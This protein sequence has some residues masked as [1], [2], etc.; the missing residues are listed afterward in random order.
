MLA[1]QVTVLHGL[2]VPSERLACLA[3]AGGLPL[4][5]AED[6]RVGDGDPERIVVLVGSVD[7]ESLD[8]CWLRPFAAWI[9]LGI[10]SDA[11]VLNKIALAASGVLVASFTTVTANRLTLARDIVEAVGSRREIGSERRDDIEL[12]I[13]EAISNALV[14][15]NLQVESMKGLT[16]SALDRF[17]ED[18]SR[19][20]SDPDFA[21]RRL[22]VSC[23]LDAGG[24]TVEIADQGAGFIVVE[25]DRCGPCGRGLDLISGIAQS[26]QLLDGGRR[27]RMRFDL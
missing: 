5:P 7:P 18:I 19:R 12:A 9:E 21:N 4:W 26:C 14:H 27:I 23:E 6:D 25:T 11:A 16:M 10:L 22:D 24:V 15:G 20:I 1:S 13:H 2:G 8:N 3:V 17:S